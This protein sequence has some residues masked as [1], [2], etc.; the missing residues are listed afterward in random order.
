MEQVIEWLSTVDGGRFSQVAVPKGTEGKDLLTLNARRLTELVRAHST[1]RIV[2]ATH[3]CT[4][5]D[6]HTHIGMHMHAHDER[7]VGSAC[8]S[9][10]S[11]SMGEK[12]ARDGT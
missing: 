11:R 9:R 1:T 2:H 4:H 10:P 7:L 8:R 3:A 6:A 5:A 12:T